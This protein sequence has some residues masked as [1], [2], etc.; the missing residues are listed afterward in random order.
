M[1]QQ[2][3]FK[4]GSLV[5]GASADGTCVVGGIL[6]VK[7]FVN[8]QCTALTKPFAALITLVRLLLGVDVAVIPQ[9]ILPAEGFTAYV[10]WIRP[11]VRVGPLMDQQVV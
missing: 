10:T 5:E 6:H 2:M 9:M 11:L 3:S 7:N 4:V 1:G 8:S